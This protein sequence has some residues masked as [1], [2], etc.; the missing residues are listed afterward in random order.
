MTEYAKGGYVDNTNVEVIINKGCDYIIP[1]AFA[2]RWKELLL[3][4]NDSDGLDKS[5]DDVVD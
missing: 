5:S 1:R 4:I 3:K 2:E